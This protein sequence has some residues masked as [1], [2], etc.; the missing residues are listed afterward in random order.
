MWKESYIA[1]K[2]LDGIKNKYSVPKECCEL[3]EKNEI[4]PNPYME[5]KALK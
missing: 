3:K 2:G 5:K 4:V 1:V